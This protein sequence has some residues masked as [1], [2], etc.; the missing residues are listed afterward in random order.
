MST[1]PEAELRTRSDLE[2]SLRE[3][4]THAR[5]SNSID[6]EDAGPGIEPGDRPYESRLGTS[7]T[8]NGN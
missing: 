7:R 5:S 2:L 3:F 6:S 4:A 8:C 1:A